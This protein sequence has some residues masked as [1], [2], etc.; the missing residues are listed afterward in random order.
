MKWSPG[1]LLNVIQL[2]HIYINHTRAC[3]GVVCMARG[4]TTHVFP[5]LQCGAAG[6]NRRPFRQ[7]QGRVNVNFLLIVY[8]I[9][10]CGN[11]IKSVTGL[12][13]SKIS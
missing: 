11:S 6:S 10:S 5:S 4:W 2:L 3:S 13:L 9:A 8:I 1:P 12:C 7:P